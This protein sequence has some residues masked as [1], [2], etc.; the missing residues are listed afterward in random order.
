MLSHSEQS[1]ALCSNFTNNTV[2]RDGQ[3]GESNQTG[4]AKWVISGTLVTSVTSKV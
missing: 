2:E 4:L 1:V 3:T